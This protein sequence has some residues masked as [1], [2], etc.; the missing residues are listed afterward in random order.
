M[1]GGVG[2]LGRSQAVRSM[3]EYGTL[4]LAW[5]SWL[6]SA[7][8]GAAAAGTFVGGM[9]AAALGWFPS[10]VAAGLLGVGVV[11]MLLDMFLDLTPNMLAIWCGILLPSVARGVDGRLGA[12]VTDLAGRLRGQLNAWTADWLGPA[13]AIALAAFGI[14]AAL[15]MARRVIKRGG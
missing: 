6:L 4:V 7:A 9:I 15:L 11:A 12:E 8:G 10:W 3:H 1:R 2:V 5:L 14:G 13:P